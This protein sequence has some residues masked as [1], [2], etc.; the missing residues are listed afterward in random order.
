MPIRPRSGRRQVVRQRKSCLQF[1]G[2]R[3]LETE[4][5]AALRVDPGHDVPDGAV[6]AASVHPL[7]NQQQRIA[8]GRVVKPLHRAQL[9][10]RVLPGVFD[11]ASSTCKWASQVVGHSLSLTFSPGRTRKSFELI[12]ISTFQ[13]CQPCCS[14]LFIYGLPVHESPA[15]SFP[16]PQ[17]PELP[18]ALAPRRVHGLA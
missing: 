6:L 2:A 17:L 18:R 10:Q 3:L 1:L 12:F 4:N 9:P 7:K 5:L 8:V 15:P 14:R 16:S 11:I 13:P